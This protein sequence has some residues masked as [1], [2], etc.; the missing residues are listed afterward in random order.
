MDEGWL[1]IEGK[2]GKERTVPFTGRLQQALQKVPRRGSYVITNRVGEQLHPMNL[3][4]VVQLVFERVGLPGAT[5]HR[6]RHTF[7]T[8]AFRAGGNP[9]AIQETMGHGS[10]STTMVYA[11]VSA[12]DKQELIKRM[13]RPSS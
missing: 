6:L 3:L 11:E 7:G 9:R 1:V 13:Q 4:R 8:E 2:G 10:L 12:K 5:V